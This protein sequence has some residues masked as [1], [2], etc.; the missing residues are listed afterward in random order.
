MTTP[1]LTHSE[2]GRR[3]A[4]TADAPSTTA[5]L[6]RRTDGKSGGLG[7]MRK[8]VVAAALAIF[9]GGTL[10]PLVAVAEE[11]GWV[12]GAP[13]PLRRGAGVKFGFTR[14]VKVG[15]KLTIL[16]RGDGWTQVR[17][18][19]GTEGWIAAG[20]LDATAPPTTRLA[21]LEAET[22]Q[23]RESLDHATREVERLESAY[24]EV[25]GR[26]SSQRSELDR[27]TQD[28]A[29]LRAGSAWADRIAGALILCTGMVLGAIWHRL[30]TRNRG[31]RLRL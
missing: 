13:L 8:V 24:S 27:L 5:T 3:A 9:V 26:D 12:R 6:C 22:T 14:S 7:F 18:S 23:L 31:T 25:S 29:K 16:S 30:A 28:N 10:L 15:D 1:S 2:P 11:A 4:P 21:E 19:D 17:T 20:Y